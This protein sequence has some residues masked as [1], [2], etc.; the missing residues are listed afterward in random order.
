MKTILTIGGTSLL[1]QHDINDQQM[2]AAIKLLKGAAQVDEQTHYGPE[3]KDKYEETAGYFCVRV[4]REV[5]AQ[6]T[7]ELLDDSEVL[8]VREFNDRAAGFEKQTLPAAA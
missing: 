7:L 1:L 6:I 5:K 4:K 2:A 8:S 3:G